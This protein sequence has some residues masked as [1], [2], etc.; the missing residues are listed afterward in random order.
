MHYGLEGEVIGER[1]VAHHIVTMLDRRDQHVAT[2]H[3]KLRQKGDVLF[4]AKHHLVRGDLLVTA[5]DPTD[6]TRSCPDPLD[7]ALQIEFNP[8]VLT[9]ATVVAG[10]ALGCPGSRSRG[11]VT[12]T[13]ADLAWSG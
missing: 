8:P 7:V 3:V 12:R 5:H 2:Q 10:R 13:N 11:R 4:V 6:E 1:E 9:H